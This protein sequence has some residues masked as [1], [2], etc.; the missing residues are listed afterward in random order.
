MGLLDPATIKGLLARYDGRAKK[1]FGQHF[2]IS[3]TVLSR[4]L[5][6]SELEDSDTVIEVGPGLGTV[7]EA[8]AP[9]VK[10]VIAIE[11]ERTMNEI[12]NE[13]LSGCPNVERYRADILRFDWQRTVAGPYKVISALPYQSATAIIRQF[14]EADHR[15]Q[16]MA[17]I[18]QAEVAKRL[19]AP[20]GHR[21][22]GALSVLTQALAR[23]RVQ[24]M[25]RASAFYPSPRVNSAIV[26]I[27]PLRARP[28]EF[29]RFRRLVRAGFSGKRKQLINSL[30]GGL[31]LERSVVATGLRAAGIDP[32]RRA[33]TLS[34]A[35]WQRLLG[36][37]KG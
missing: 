35:E 9:Q 28:A 1:S 37:L 14:L 16:L 5:D 18:V 12:L 24:G 15:P 8:I 29:A 20:P 3:R 36:M 2:L 27:I 25:V 26:T 11:V 13:T 30:A 23:V 21:E 33:E 34:L 31:R 17:V 4:L 6:A 7:T 22:R 32:K 19:V 10:R